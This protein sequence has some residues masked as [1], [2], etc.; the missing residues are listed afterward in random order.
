MFDI[1]KNVLLSFGSRAPSPEKVYKDSGSCSGSC[2]T[3]GEE[4]G[5][6]G[7]DSYDVIIVGG[8]A[9]G[10][11]LAGRLSED[12]TKQVL[13]VEAGRDYP[14]EKPNPD[15][16]SIFP[17]STFDPQY[18][19]P[20][21]QATVQAA[22]AD[23][24]MPPSAPFLQGLGI[25]GSSNLTGMFAMR[26]H[27]D[28]YDEWARRG[29]KGWTWDDVLPYFRKLETDRDF[30]GP[31]HGES[32]PM[33][34]RRI[35]E[36]Q[37]GPFSTAVA[38]AVR[39]RGFPDIA[40]YLAEF[41]DGLS[42]LAVSNLPGR[43]VSAAAAYLTPAVRR[44]PNLT[45]LPSTRADRIHFDE[46]QVRGVTVL[47][48]SGRRELLAPL[49]IVTAGAVQTPALLMRSGIGPA[50]S[51]AQLGIPVVADRPGVGG[52][53]QHQAS[54]NVAVHLKKRAMQ[55]STS[56]SQAQNCLRFSSGDHGGEDADLFLTPINRTDWHSLGR[57]IGSVGVYVLKNFSTG[58]VSLTS[59]D[60]LVAPKIS[61]RLFSDERDFERLVKGFSLVVSLLTDPQVAKLR[62]EAFIPNMAAAMRLHPRSRWNRVRATLAAAALDLPALR[63]KTLDVVDLDKLAND[64]E[65]LREFVLRR[66]AAFGGIGGTARMGEADDPNSVVDPAG[67]VYGVEGLRVADASVF[68]STVRGTTHL[69]V[70]M[71][72]EKLADVIRAAT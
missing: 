56:P 72:A 70:L 69:P 52:N 51:L 57:R 46:R 64:R 44:R 60:V 48:E 54:L 10:C 67:C 17:L 22:R 14:P 29:A 50:F 71:V 27:P 18:R 66:A 33:P 13:L 53:F 20:D 26:G 35:L 9:A 38:S 19:W 61:C 45:I 55:P 59:S 6:L 34:V 47:C 8:G 36:A 42:S 21:L 58:T 12:G 1:R 23:G 25:G 43:R 39:K 32:G 37:W 11:V 4:I 2:V 16:L 63:R 62:N 49:I 41:G 7:R 5:N 65:A 40:D 68:P 15:I 31:F 24:T 28:D 30:D 3:S